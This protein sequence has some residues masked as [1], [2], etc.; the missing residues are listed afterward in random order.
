MFILVELTHAIAMQTFARVSISRWF[1]KIRV[2]GENF[3][4]SYGF[5]ADQS[6][7]DLVAHWMKPHNAQYYFIDDVHGFDYDPETVSEDNK[8]LNYH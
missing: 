4:H 8:L 1:D 7:T 3:L 2:F 5:K 6:N